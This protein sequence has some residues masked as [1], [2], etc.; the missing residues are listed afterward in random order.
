MS[1]RDRDLSVDGPLKEEAKKLTDTYFKILLPIMYPN[2][3]GTWKSAIQ[4]AA[5]CIDEK[6]K[7]VLNQHEVFVN[8]FEGILDE[9]RAWSTLQES[10]DRQIQALDRLKE[11]VLA[12]NN[13]NEKLETNTYPTP[14]AKS[15]E[16][17]SG[18]PH[19]DYYPS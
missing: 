7:T 16:R 18:L 15:G 8:T 10:T 9:H 11:H 17:S 12:Q 19:P 4:S 3:S 13:K 14:N 6:R 5:L 2:V 1:E